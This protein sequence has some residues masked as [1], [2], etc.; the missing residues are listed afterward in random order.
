MA[1]DRVKTK[2]NAEKAL[3][4]GKIPE[5]I[6]EMQKLADDNPRDIQVLNQIGQLHLR[7]GNREMA[8]PCFLK[9]AD[10]FSKS[11]FFTKAVAS[12]KIV[13]REAPENLSAW[14]MLASLSEQQGFT[15]EA[16]G[17]Y[18]K[19]AELSVRTGNLGGVIDVQKKLLELEPDN[20]KI[21]V[22]LGDNLIKAGRKE[23]GV[24]HYLKAGGKLIAQGLVKEG[25]R[26][27]ERALQLDPHN[28][29]ALE[30]AVKTQLAHQQGDV[31]LQLLDSLLERAPGAEGMLLLKADVLTETRQFAAAEE[32]CRQAC[33]AH[34]DSPGAMF[35]LV[36]AFV[37]QQKIDE[38]SGAIGAWLKATGGARATEAESLYEEILRFSTGHVP[39]LRGLVD[40]ARLSG[41]RER[42]VN[43]LSALADNA[44]AQGPFE[45]AREAL[46]ELV[47]FD[48]NNLQLAEKLH[49]VE[50]KMGLATHPGGQAPAVPQPPGRDAVKP[51]PSAPP[52]DL[53]VIVE[54][55]GEAEIEIEMDDLR[56]EPVDVTASFSKAASP[57]PGLAGAEVSDAP[58][59]EEEISLE[60]P[61]GVQA[62]PPLTAREADDIR[63]HLTEAEVFLKY[64][65]VEK[66]IAELQGIIKKV[67]DHI[68]A[69]Q[70]L[71]AVFRNQKKTDKVIRQMLKLAAVFAQQGDE[72]K[73]AQ[74]VEE[75]RALDPSHKALL[76]FERASGPSAI[77]IDV[78]GLEK[79]IK[80]GE[81]KAPTPA[82]SKPSIEL[83]LEPLVSVSQAPAESEEILL[84]TEEE[85]PAA[86]IPLGELRAVQ[87]EDLAP[88][89]EPV[90]VPPID[91]N[92]ELDVEEALKDQPSTSAADLAE[93]L[94]EAEFYLNQELFGEALRALHLLEENWPD[95]PRVKR[96]AE[97]LHRAAPATA[98]AAQPPEA[99]EELPMVVS[100]PLT[101]EPQVLL[102]EE[103]TFEPS[104]A[105]EHESGDEA[106]PDGKELAIAE[107]LLGEPDL[108]EHVFEEPAQPA[109]AQPEK[110]GAVDTGT[111][112]RSR[113]R[114]KVSVKDILPEETE[115]KAEEGLFKENEYYDLASELGAALEGLQAPEESLFE[116][117]AKSP[118]EM[119]FEEVFEEFKKGV[120]KKVSE[121][122]YATHYNLGIAY[123]EM[124]LLDEAI[125]EFQLAA[126][127][128][129]FFVEC[130]SM[131]GIC[132][133][134]K[135][136]T[137]LAEK[138]Y[139]KG[140]AAP[141]F[142]D[143]VYVGLKYD[144]A[145]TLA[146]QG[147]GEEANDLFKEVYAI[148][149]SYRDVK[150]RIK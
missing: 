132:F 79:S 32:V 1:I 138:W 146:E 89:V 13:T 33:A 10:L 139:R 55:T 76:E 122:D 135:G 61:P 48:P 124:E 12:L 62:A 82:P 70:K 72:E 74:L 147:R 126:R 134:Q 121:E 119:S 69:H 83:D 2:A 109:D 80:A 68:H 23:E 50:R 45:V 73:S 84:P 113:A 144:L 22:Q 36:R 104:R 37:M 3:K 9:V 16:L 67:P 94:E 150:D 42:L 129:Q 11:G 65:L 148:Q 63:D 85:V 39:S 140:I 78:E 21:Q 27:Y 105:E 133:R 57:P 127:S 137:E 93:Q 41:K 101:E 141:G 28:F 71:I 59:E 136:L 110:A 14:E 47:G 46:Q 107:P 44:A 77:T 15:R 43:V 125:G 60:E 88:A 53:E 102:E 95:E 29:A 128:P 20:L 51:S 4:A 149:A 6:R 90:G 87:E 5:A 106:V 24:K 66:A 117:E 115:P 123:K 131:L 7:Q 114:M 81:P 19:V 111:T 120:E 30:A 116:E 31:A 18:E 25:A 97:K 17:A 26:M 52:E 99:P 86:G 143:E 103:P 8:V 58:E 40:V 56:I 34:A 35:R 118:E 49:A 108:D 92:L 64:G 112:S 96:F 38:A 100:G 145:D 75:A 98:A 54:E 91:E 130:C 142:A